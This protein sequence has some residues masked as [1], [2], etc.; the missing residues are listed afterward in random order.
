VASQFD[1]T[2]MSERNAMRARQ[3][4]GQRCDLCASLRGKTTGCPSIRGIFERM[5]L[6]PSSAPLAHQA[7]IELQALSNLL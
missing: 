6:R 7:I 4:A 2:P 3:A 1:S 5:A